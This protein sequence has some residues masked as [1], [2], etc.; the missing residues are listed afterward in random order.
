[1][2]YARLKEINI[3][4]GVSETATK[5]LSGGVANKLRRVSATLLCRDSIGGTK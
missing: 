2:T 1:M 5:Q 3:I 4:H